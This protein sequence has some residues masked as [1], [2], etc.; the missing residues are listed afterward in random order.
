[1]PR[2]RRSSRSSNTSSGS[3]GGGGGGRERRRPRYQI[4]SVPLAIPGQ[5]RRR[6][7]KI[8]LWAFGGVATIA[9]LIALV[10]TGGF[11]WFSRSA[12]DTDGSRLVAGIAQRV[13]IVRDPN[14]IPHI[15]ATTADD[16]YFAQGFVHAQDRLAQMDMM[17]MLA[18]GRLAEVIGRPGLAND[19]F[20][21]GMDLVG[22]AEQSL[23]VMSPETRRVFDAYARGVNSLLTTPNLVLPPEFQLIGRQPEPW[24]VVDS[25][26]WGQ[27][28]ALQLSGN[29]RDELARL[30]LASRH[31]VEALTAL[32]PDWPADAATSIKQQA[33]TMSPEALERTLAALPAPLGPSH[34]SN[35]WVFSGA[36][37][38]TGKPLLAND[39]HLQLSGPSVWHLLRLDAPGFKR[40]GASA[41]GVPG[42][43]LGHNGRIAWGMTTTGADTF[44]LF[45][46]RQIENDPT[47]YQTV[48][49]PKP[50]DVRT[51]DIAIKNEA[52]RLRIV[53][54]RTH[55][56][57]VLADLTNDAAEAAAPGEVLVLASTMFHGPNTTA[58]AL[59]KIN[60]AANVAQFIKAAGEWAAPVQ[61]LFVA[62]TEG[63][64]ALTTAGWIPDRKQ[65]DGWTPQPGWNGE[66]DWRG[67][68]A[69]DRLPRVIDPEQGFLM[70][71]NN[72]LVG[73]SPEIFI[74]RD[75]DAPFRALRLQEGLADAT[76]QDLLNAR[77]WQLDHVSAFAQ[78]FMAKIA[79]WN[80]ADHATRFHLVLLREWDGEMLRS[81]AEPLIFNAWMRALRNQALDALLKHDATSL[82]A[83][84]RE[85]PFL[86]LAIAS[87][88]GAL[89]EQMDCR[90]LLDQ[91]LRAA[92]DALTQ[93]YGESRSGWRWGNTHTAAFENPLWSRIPYAKNVTRFD[94]AS[95]GDNFTVNRG[96][97]GRRDTLTDFP[98]THGASLRALYDLANLDRAQFIIAP[99]QSGH[100]LS[101]N[102]G[103]LAPLWA[104]GRYVSIAGTRDALVVDGRILTLAPR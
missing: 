93:R 19:R 78:Q 26:L 31:S 44:D 75:W 55:H 45:I 61:N 37:T 60:G 22:L 66:Y 29:W 42:I 34:A 67:M 3:S 70:N 86:L 89:C 90:A 49:G 84:G 21:R 51:Y 17:R 57:V 82:A 23:Q 94:I 27:L 96:G 71:A 98:H 54:R 68:V 25:L 1:M 12:P 56:G 64:V 76:G 16:A 101:S 85:F 95:D 2:R 46:E 73:A 79:S 92:A 81:R 24:T 6:L 13:E 87:N 11:L 63:H 10:L 20:M 58:E 47:R 74:S 88:E 77:R 102:W 69:A 72:R 9:L 40:V 50:F 8:T 62:D 39:P 99:G 32:W 52:E 15:F 14:G 35:A 38:A 33:Q 80:P 53:V 28:M 4:S 36:R 65:G 30:R 97:S 83:S 100:P 7:L 59:F 48:A 18:R 41:P 104:N 43:V 91:S 5:R 103:D